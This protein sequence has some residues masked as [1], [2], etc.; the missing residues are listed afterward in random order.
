[1]DYHKKV[2][3]LAKEVQAAKYRLSHLE[4]E[5]QEAVVQ[6]CIAHPGGLR[7][8]SRSLGISAAYAC[9]LKMKRRRVSEAL[10]ARILGAK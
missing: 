10:I 7:S 9:D 2:G 6:L 8:W 3:K 4:S 5:L 1:M